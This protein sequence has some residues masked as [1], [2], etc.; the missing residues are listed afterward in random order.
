MQAS[1]IKVTKLWLKKLFF[2]I[3]H[4]FSIHICTFKDIQ[5][6]SEFGQL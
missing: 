6:C 2:N 4:H 3:F 1:T 5:Q